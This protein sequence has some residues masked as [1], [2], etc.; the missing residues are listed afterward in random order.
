MLERKEH[1]RLQAVRESY[2]ARKAKAR[3]DIAR[4]QRGL[5]A[6]KQQRFQNES[7]EL[8]KLLDDLGIPPADL[9]AALT[10]RAPL[11]AGIAERLGMARAEGGREGDGRGDGR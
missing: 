7:A 9:M 8:G 4:S 2:R 3:E 10:G 5:D 6:Y 11:P 1:E